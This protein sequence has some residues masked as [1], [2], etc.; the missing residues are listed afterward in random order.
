VVAAGAVVVAT[1]AAVDADFN[2]DFLGRN[3]ATSFLPNESATRDLGASLA[4]RL[5][6]GD[7][8]LLSGELG[9]GK[10][11]LV[12]GLL[13]ALGVAEPVRSP[14]FN[15][16]QVFSTTPPVVHADLYRLKSAEGLGLEDYL[17]THILLIEWPDRARNFFR[18]ERCWNVGIEAQDEGRRATITPPTE[19]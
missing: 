17:D 12:R 19:H 13:V 7:V 9:A 2:F 14:T 5:V 3:E 10:T 8:V 16:I 18:T 6:A 4:P 1:A 11:T 15:L